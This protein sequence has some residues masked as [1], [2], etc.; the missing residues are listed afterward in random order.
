MDSFPWFLCR[1]TSCLEEKVA[2]FWKKIAKFVAAEENKEFWLLRQQQRF[3]KPK[4]YTSKLVQKLKRF[5][6]KDILKSKTS[7]SQAKFSDF[8]GKN[9]NFQ[10]LQKIAKNLAILG[11]QNV[12]KAFQKSPKLR[13][14]AISGHTVFVSYFNPWTFNKWT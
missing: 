11:K 5:K 1:V 3:L 6:S 9:I 4:I 14:I 13:Q 2:R 12:V 8:N 7:K 10:Y